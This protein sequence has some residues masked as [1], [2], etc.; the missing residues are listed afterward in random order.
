[1]KKWKS[2][3]KEKNTFGKHRNRTLSSAA[4]PVANALSC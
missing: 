1:M 3:G 4:D 2:S